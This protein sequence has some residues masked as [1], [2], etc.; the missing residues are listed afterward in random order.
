LEKYLFFFSRIFRRLALKYH[1]DKNSEA[2][3]ESAFKELSEAYAV[4]SKCGRL[5][6]L[7]VCICRICL[8]FYFFTEPFLNYGGSGAYFLLV[9]NRG[10]QGD[11]VYLC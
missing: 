7:I 1:P 2:G 10:L 4:L 11:V 9:E 8:V 6:Q 3:A 5:F